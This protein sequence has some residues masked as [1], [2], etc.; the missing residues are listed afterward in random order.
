MPGVKEAGK[1]QA[2]AAAVAAASVMDAKIAGKS[3]KLAAG[4]VLIEEA[5][6][7]AAEMKEEILKESASK[8]EENK[9]ERDRT[10][11]KRDA[12]ELSGQSKWFGIEGK[13][14]KDADIKWTLEMVKEQWEAFQN[15]LPAENKELSVHLDELSE[16]Y[17]ALLEAILTHTAGEEQAIQIDRLNQVLVMKLNLLLDVD[18]KDLLKLLEQTGQKDTLGLIESS[19]YKQTTGESISARAADRFFARGNMNSRGNTRYFM[20]ESQGQGAGSSRGK[21][22]VY[23]SSVSSASAGGL[24]A[25]SE[26][27]R[28]YELTKGRNVRMNQSLDISRQ[29][30]EIQMNQ[31]ARNV[32]SARGGSGGSGIGAGNGSDGVLGSKSIPGGKELVNANRF[33]AHVNGSGNLFTNPAISARNEEV[34]GLLA[35]MTSIKGQVYAANSGRNSAISTPLRNALNQ[36]I[37]YYLTQKGAYKVY[38]YTANIYE[39]TKNPQKAIEEGIEYAYRI[40]MEKKGDSVYRQQAAY[41]EEAGF[42]QMLL[43]G[44]SAQ[45][46]LLRGMRLLEGNWRDFLR[47]IGESEKKGI[48]LT[49]QKHS[50]WGILMEAANLEKD[51]GEKKEKKVV[52]TE[53]ACIAALV[54]IYL[55]FRLF[56]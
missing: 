3:E 16:L 54:I 48:V 31:R 45:A 52:L 55:C 17:L 34:M 28:F 13:I 37:D 42:F 53:I 26:E 21:N 39:R 51:Q 32:S 35:A 40:F 50:P 9:N 19:V 27:G 41:S 30:G 25:A 49:M 12:S 47:S 8:K 2:S 4:Q 20:P 36:M 1:S 44:Q 38:G 11:E 6:R 46:D 18:L 23:T 15:W 5:A 43:K 33:A 56:F 14:L 22:N 7:H 24:S 10:E 29:S